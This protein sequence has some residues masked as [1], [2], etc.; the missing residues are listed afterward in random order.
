MSERI[1]NP[2][3]ERQPRSGTVFGDANQQY[4][5]RTLGESSWQTFSNW[6][7]RS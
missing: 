5:F 2:A 7:I 1:G 6:K 4:K 3:D